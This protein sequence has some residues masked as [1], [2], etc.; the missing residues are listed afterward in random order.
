MKRSKFNLSHY[1]LQTA[2]MGKLYPVGCVE[3]LPGDTF[4]HS[5]SAFLRFS[6]MLA[7]VMHPVEVRIHHWFVPNRL[8]WAPWEQ[9]ITGGE[10]GNQ[11][12]A[13]PQVNRAA[14]D[15]DP[16]LD[17]LGIAKP[18]SGILKVNSLPIRA[19]NT[20][21]NEFYRDEDLQAKASVDDRTTKNISWEKDFFTAARPWTQK[22]PEV[23]LPLGDKAPIMGLGKRNGTYEDS[24]VS[25]R[26]AG[27]IDTTFLKS[28]IMNADTPNAN[29]LYDMEEDPDNPGYPNL[30][31]DL[32]RATGVT[33]NDLREALALQRFAEARSRYGSR[34][35]E[36][37]RY[38]GVRSG[39]ARLQRPEYLGGGKQTISFSEVLQTAQDADN[40]VGTLRGHGI[41]AVR[42]NSYRRFFEEH[43]Y[44][45]SLMSVRPKTIYTQAVHKTFLRTQREDFWQKELEHIGQQEVY[46]AEVYSDQTANVDVFG[47]QDRYREY[48]EMPSTIH[49]EFRDLLDF[50]HLGRSFS[51]KPALNEEFIKCE[52]AKRPF[53][54]QSQDVMWCAINHRLRAR[55]LVSRNASARIF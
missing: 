10:D 28:S 35:T 54:I 52:P 51:S 44:V 9:F 37:L 3:V 1:R 6:P 7:P 18:A 23:V 4:D 47:Y 14:T 12:P 31:A 36:Y 41:G 49:G 5:T 40:P 39:D 33:V 38:L 27:G 15:T 20:I 21:W 30:Y 19:Y 26:E 8:V 29:Q 16:L 53:A 13:L 45:I 22:G 34:Y 55:R 50:W 42:T 48:R 25:V 24:N 2:D 43:G 46:S 17:Y 11:R 32:S